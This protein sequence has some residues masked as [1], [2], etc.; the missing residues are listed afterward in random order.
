M[1]K[2]KIVASILTTSLLVT[3]LVGCVGS[4]NKANTNSNDSKVQESVEN[5]C[6]FNDL[7][8]YVGKTYN[9]VSEKRELEVK[10]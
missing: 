6:D 9:E 5:Q 4:N 3:S 8:T 10:I 7:R 2:R 1:N